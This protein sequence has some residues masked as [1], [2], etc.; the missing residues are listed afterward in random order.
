WHLNIGAIV[1]WALSS[2]WSLVHVPPPAEIA[3]FDTIQAPCFIV[4]A[5]T[6][7]GINITSTH[8]GMITANANLTL[9]ADGFVQAGGTF[10]A[11]AFTIMDAGDWSESSTTGFSAGTGTVNFNS[12]TSQTI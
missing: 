3:T 11:G 6:A 2:N 5:S 12:G 8:T 9:G 7:S 4:T 10:S 1:A